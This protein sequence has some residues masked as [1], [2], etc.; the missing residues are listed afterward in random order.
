MMVLGS[1]GRSRNLPLELRTLNFGAFLPKAILPSSPARRL[2]I[3]FKLDF[4]FREILAGTRRER[5]GG[6]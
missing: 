5:E 4:K 1:R 6:K 3:A 2:G